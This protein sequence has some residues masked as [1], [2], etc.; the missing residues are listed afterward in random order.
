MLQGTLGALSGGPLSGFVL[1]GNTT[2]PVASLIALS[3]IAAD[4]APL[5]APDKRERRAVPPLSS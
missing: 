3:F 4:S 1:E 5:G 2:Y